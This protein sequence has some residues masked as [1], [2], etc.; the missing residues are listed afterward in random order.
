MPDTHR[1][2]TK[3]LSERGKQKLED[4]KGETRALLFRP[5]TLSTLVRYS[6]GRY[7][8]EEGRIR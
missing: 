8:W 2:P 5:S 1:D 4:G 6:D 7:G 3:Y